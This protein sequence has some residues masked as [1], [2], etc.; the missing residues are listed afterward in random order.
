MRSTVAMTAKNVAEE[1]SRE[2][3]RVRPA[4]RPPPIEVD[5]SLAMDDV[6]EEDMSLR[7]YS[8]TIGAPGANMPAMWFGIVSTWT[9]DTPAGECAAG[10]A[11]FVYEAC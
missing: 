7:W 5:P 2:A 8:I 9:M 1:V 3:G 6:P 4:A 10:C 11:L